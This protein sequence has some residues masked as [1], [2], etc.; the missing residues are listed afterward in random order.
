VAR[1]FVP[2]IDRLLFVASRPTGDAG[3]ALQHGVAVC[4]TSCR[5]ARGQA[6]SRVSP[7]TAWR[8]RRCARPRRAWGA[9]RPRN[10]RASAAWHRRRAACFVAPGGCRRRRA[11]CVVA[12][13]RG[14][15][16][17]FP[18]DAHGRPA[19]DGRTS[20]RRRVGVLSRQDGV[21]PVPVKEAEAMERQAAGAERSVPGRLSNRA[22]LPSL[23]WRSEPD[24]FCRGR[25]RCRRDG[26]AGSAVRCPCAD[27]PSPAGWRGGAMAVLALGAVR[28][29]A[30][31]AGSANPAAR[32]RLVDRRGPWCC[33][34]RAAAVLRECGGCAA[35]GSAGML[36]PLP[37][38][39]WRA[40]AL[41]GR[42][43]LCQALA[44]QTGVAESAGYAR[45][46]GMLEQ[47]H[48][49]ARC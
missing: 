38:R 43:V 41:P 33:R 14:R 49:T 36:A 44:R 21:N 25:S 12:R 2:R 27:A 35:S 48:N 45:W 29:A 40:K 32:W 46:S 13:A 17:C 30:G 18:A 10:C 34:P 8:S 39:C 15:L 37:R 7:P 5:S 6:A 47:T 16:R 1:L 19:C 42:G 23:A 22:V 3:P 28:R 11:A 9:T 24:T 26:R 31:R 20:A 4:S